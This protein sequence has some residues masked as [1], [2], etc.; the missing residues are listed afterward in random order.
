MVP[1]E[2]ISNIFI[3]TTFYHIGT[4]RILINFFR[5]EFFL[6]DYLYKIGNFDTDYICSAFAGEGYADLWNLDAT[7]LFAADGEKIRDRR[8]E[9]GYHDT[10]NHKYLFEFCMVPNTGFLG[11][12]DLL[13]KDAELK[14]CF[15]RANV[16]QVLMCKT[17]VWSGLEDVK[18]DIKNCYAIT[19]YVSSPSLRTYFDSI[20]YAPLR[21]EFEDCEVFV[22]SVPQG[23]TNL[24]FDNLRGGNTPSHMFVGFIESSALRGKHNQAST[25]F[26]PHGVEVFNI[27]V[28]G[29]SVN[30]YPLHVKH[31]IPT[32]PFQK[33]ISCTNRQCNINGGKMMSPNEF[34]F[35]WLWSHTFEAEDCAT[36]WIGVDFKLKTAF[37]E[38]MSMIVW[39]ISPAA[40]AID[41]YQQLEKINL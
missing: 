39:L 25:R 4:I 1:D 20:D 2:N 3:R 30:G 21:Y 5:N 16:E 34:E 22:K 32:I 11:N 31:S 40:V 19:E 23:E 38:P 35:N 33:F 41:K 18:I 10:S 37:A 36:G 9:I 26:G 15:D 27:T 7:Q 17:D 8:V 28:N 24:R 13:L 6:S 29:T 12:P 14:L